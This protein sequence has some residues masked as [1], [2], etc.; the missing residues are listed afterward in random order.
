MPY[1]SLG[2]VYCGCF[3]DHNFFFFFTKMI[4]ASL[5][6]YFSL[7][8]KKVV[9]ISYFTLSRIILKK[10]IKFIIGPIHSFNQLKLGLPQQ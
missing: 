4:H 1:R 3:R 9:S 10:Y 7:K 5:R 6:H 8:L 2:F